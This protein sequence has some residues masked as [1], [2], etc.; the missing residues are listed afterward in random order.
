M[1]YID[2]QLNCKYLTRSPVPIPTHLP[3]NSSNRSDSTCITCGQIQSL[4]PGHFGHIELCVPI[5]HP[6]FFPK[7]LMLMKMKCLACHNFRLGNR[8]TRIICTKLHLIDVGR[9]IEALE[10]DGTLACIAENAV[11]SN[12]KLNEGG[13]GGAKKKAEIAG[14]AGKAIDDILDEMLALGPPS[15]VVGETAARGSLTTHERTARRHILK[16]FQGACTKCIKCANCQ[17]FSPKIRHDQFNK[18]FQIALSTKS[19]KNNMGNRI[20]IRS[21]CSIVGGGLYNDDDDED[22]DWPDSEDD[23]MDEYEEESEEEEEEEENDTGLIDDEAAED[24]TNKTSKKKKKKKGNGNDEDLEEAGATVSTSKVDKDAKQ[25][26]FMNNLEIEA[27]CRLTWE[28]QPLICS[29]FF[30]SAHAPEAGLDGVRDDVFDSFPYVTDEEEDGVG[31]GSNARRSRPRSTSNAEQIQGG[32]KGYSMFFLRAVPVPPSRFRPPVIMG[33][34]TVEHSQ[35]YYLS[36][37][38]ESNAQLRTLFN[39][40]H[41]LT[42]EEGEL[43]NALTNG[44]DG[45]D[46]ARQLKKVRDEKDKTQAN[47]LRIWVELQTTVNCFMDSSRDPRTSGA[48][49]A[50]NGIRQLLEKKEGIFRKHMMGK[51][52]NFACRSVISPD[53]YIGTNEIGLPLHF[54]KTLTFPTPVTSLN[55]AEMQKLVRRGPANYPG[56]VWVEFPT[57]QRIDLTQMKDRGRN[58]VASRLLSSS[59][60]VGIVKVGRQLR[61]GDMVLMNRQVSYFYLFSLFLLARERKYRKVEV[62]DMNVYPMM[63]Y[64]SHAPL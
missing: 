43:K 46:T 28:K 12:S 45:T 4:C 30:G 35:N 31:G 34:M 5:M 52:V 39:L 36:K 21:A 55:I 50:P 20:R 22:E 1:S 23:V 49:N 10:L 2:S 16:S 56:A 41:E 13:G 42:R 27:Q 26:S 14:L 19:K 60:G 7:L 51:R 48:G 57:G 29:K 64:F 58:A 8:Q 17:A 33:Q 59:S 18:M 44:A 9:Y 63:R 6:L 37:V 15:I 32:G 11:G 61:D 3:N 53:P 24:N 54:A 47:L 40:T 38:L 62:K 25:D